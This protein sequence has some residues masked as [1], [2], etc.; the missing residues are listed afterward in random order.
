M[1]KPLMMFAAFG[2][3]MIVASARAA[4]DPLGARP[5]DKS[6]RI[7]NLDFPET[8]QSPGLDGRRR[9]VLRDNTNQGRY[10]LRARS[11]GMKS[12]HAGQFWI[13]GY[14][15]VK[16]DTPQGTLRSLPFVL[17]KPFVRFL[18]AGGSKPS[19]R[20]EIVRQDTQAVVFQ[21]SGDETENLEAGRRGS[22]RVPRQ[23]G[24][25]SV[26]SIARAAGPPWGHLN[27]DDL[28]ALGDPSA[29][30]VATS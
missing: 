25:S 1:R 30:R 17:T 13:G 2:L 27:F 12:E 14:E 23:G 11:R 8:S 7:L 16:Q 3:S 21:A 4:D 6:G 18:V 9:G 24:F 19:T 5:T 28:G 22:L 29:G 15:V 26:W 20:V 10:R